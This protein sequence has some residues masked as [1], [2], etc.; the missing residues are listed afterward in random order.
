MKN[1]DIPKGERE[2]IARDIHDLIGQ[3]LTALKFMIESFKT[4]SEKDKDI[5]QETRD[6][7]GTLQVDV[8]KIIGNLQSE[9]TPK[10]PLKRKIKP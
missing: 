8:C 6:L 10:S 7:I 3:P 4:T 2:K 9:N 5:L 1:D